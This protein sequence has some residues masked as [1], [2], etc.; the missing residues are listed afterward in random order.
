MRVISGGV[1][2]LIPV[3]ERG[4]KQALSAPLAGQ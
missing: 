3:A 1:S 2:R 4:L